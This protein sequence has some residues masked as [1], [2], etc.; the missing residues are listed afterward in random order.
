[1]IQPVLNDGDLT[2]RLV[3]VPIP[4]YCP[5]TRCACMIGF[6][7]LVWQL[8]SSAADAATLAKLGRH[9]LFGV[10]VCTN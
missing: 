9:P 3:F 2:T 4:K 7:R 5:C 10:T 1:M 8:P 6:Y